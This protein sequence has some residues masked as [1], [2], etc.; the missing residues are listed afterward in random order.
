MNAEFDSVAVSCRS[1]VRDFGAGP[2]MVRVLRGVDLEVRAGE[3]TMLVGP[4]GCGKTT[5]VSIVTGLLEPSGGTVEVLGHDL[6]RM[7][8]ADRVAFRRREIGFVFQQYNLLPSLTAA[9]NASVPL[10][11]AGMGYR[12]AEERARAVLASLGLGDRVDAKPNQL[13]GGQQ[14]RVAIARALVHEPRLVVC[15]EPT[16]ALDA[17]SGRAV[18]E[19]LSGIARVPGRAVVVVTHDNRV[20]DF[21]DRMAHLDDGRVVRTESRRASPLPVPPPAPRTRVPGAVAA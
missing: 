6:A 15:D 17:K 19:I 1:V 8:N 9:E 5:L 2:T 11:A 3:I 10:L 16:A 18:M 21:A 20:F 12:E 13:S 4:S 14:Q 7:G